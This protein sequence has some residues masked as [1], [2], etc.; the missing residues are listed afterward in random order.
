MDKKLSITIKLKIKIHN[1]EKP[2]DIRCK[3]IWNNS[4]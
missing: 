2:F 4:I 3:Y 1:H